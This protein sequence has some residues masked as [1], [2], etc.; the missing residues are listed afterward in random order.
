MW[1]P[2]GGCRRGHGW[3]VSPFRR[4]TRAAWGARRGRAEPLGREVGGS[5]H[6]LGGYEEFLP[7]VAERGSGREVAGGYC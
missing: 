3:A 6:E 2:V 7:A 5:L 1:L 4:R